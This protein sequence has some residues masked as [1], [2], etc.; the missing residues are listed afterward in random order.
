MTIDSY[1]DRQECL[2]ILRYAGASEPVIVHIQLVTDGCLLV[3]RRCSARMDL[4][5]A[6]AMLHDLG[7]ARTHGLDHAQLGARM[8]R[9]MGLPEELVEIIRRHLGAGMDADEAAALGLDRMETFPRTLEERI[10]CHVDSLAG[11]DKFY[12]IEKAV[13][14]LV[15]KGLPV[16]AERTREMH[17]T[18]SRECGEDLDAIL[19]G[20]PH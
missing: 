9:E 17:A 18:L 20:L 12:T 16:V 2:R 4:V 7:R 10:V 13:S 3:G 1:P 5:E 11:S 15:R 14:N 19:S 8:A 6:G